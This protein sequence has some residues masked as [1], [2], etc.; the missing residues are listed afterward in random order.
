MAIVKGLPE[1][2]NRSYTP[3]TTLTLTFR[4]EHVATMGP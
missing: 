4:Q 1:I 2:A 3:F